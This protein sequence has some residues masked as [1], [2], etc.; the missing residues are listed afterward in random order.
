VWVVAGFLLGLVV[1]VAL[2]GFHTGPHSHF[3]AGV[4][5]LVAALWLAAMAVNGQSSSL[6]WTLLGA[7]LA[8]SAAV[9]VAAR[10]AWTMK[11][12]PGGHRIRN[13][14]GAMG[15]ALTDL[16]PEGIVRVRGEQWSASSLNGN[17]AA[18]TPIQVINLEGL[19]VG[20]WGDD[21]ETAALFH[22]GEVL[23]FSDHETRPDILD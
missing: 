15:V 7:D 5:G 9:G 16:C 3:A 10:K 11:D 18:G 14:E 2:V 13:V 23:P 22:G 21:P 20:V 4:L 8:V 19:R 12:L 17:F 1:L 6:L